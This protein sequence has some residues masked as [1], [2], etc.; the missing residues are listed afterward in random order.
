[1]PDG[2]VAAIPYTENRLDNARL[3]AA[4]PDMLKALELVHRDV[5]SEGY[6]N[7]VRLH[8]AGMSREAMDAMDAA[9]G[10]AKGRE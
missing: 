10:K 9:I 8:L 1:M 2:E 6:S 5:W 7:K 4:A 3:I